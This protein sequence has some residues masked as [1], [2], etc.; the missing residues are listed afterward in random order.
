M[1]ERL[2]HAFFAGGLRL[3]LGQLVPGIAGDRFQTDDVLGAE[4]GDR[5]AKMALLPVRRQSSRATS[6]VTCSVGARPISLNVSP[7]LRSE[8][9]LRKGDCS[10]STARACLRVPSKTGSPVELMKSARTTV[11]FSVS[12]AAF[13]TGVA[14]RERK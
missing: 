5:S 3:L 9:M 14:E 13:V 1:L 6:T 7:T 10:R 11:S 2:E 4:A 12:G 8:R